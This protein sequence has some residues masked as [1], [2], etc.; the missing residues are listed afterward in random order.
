MHR[1]LPL[2]I[3]ILFVSIS[4]AQASEVLTLN[5]FIK[6]AIIKNPQHQVSAQNYLIALEQNKSAKSLED[7]NLVASGLIQ[8]SNPAAASAFSASHQHLEGYSLGLSKYIANTGTALSIEHSNTRLAAEYPAAAAA[9][10]PVNRYYLSNVKISIVQP[11]LKNAFGLAARNGLLMSDYSLQLAGLKL[12]ED[13]EEFITL[14]HQ[15]YI[16]WQQCHQNV[17][18]YSDKV[19]KVENQLKLVERQLQYGLSEELDLV[20]FKQKVQAY[21]IMLEQSKLACKNQTTKIS[22]TVGEELSAYKPEE[23]VKNGKVLP[24][25]TAATYLAAESNLR[26][27][28]DLLA[29]LQKKNLETKENAELM[30]VNLVAQAN[31]GALATK[32]SDTYS[33]L[34]DN[35]EYTLTISASRPLG[36]TQAAAESKAAKAEYEKTIKQNEATLLNAQTGLSALYAGL[37]SLNAM[38]ELNEDNLKLAEKRLALE[39]KK[40]EQGRSSGFFLLQAEDDLLQATN[41]N[42]ETLFAREKII[43]QIKSFTD[44]YLIEYKDILKL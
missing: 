17:Q 42:N 28:T 29:S 10:I 16:T 31:P 13:W 15:D 36:N 34:G 30:D 43:S 22:N 19:K 7:W 35:N 37:E 4:F 40:F 33:N 18:I 23:F 27:T 38:I 41:T 5:Q 6:T 21:K 11:L 25:E 12:S 20:Q 2:I 24:E 1:K 9:F 44:Q 39:Q 3:T 14:L 32:F 8:D 26:K